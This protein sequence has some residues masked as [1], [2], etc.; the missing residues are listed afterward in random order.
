MPK[1]QAKALWGLVLA[2]GDG[3]RLQS[4]T[5]AVS[6]H[7]IPKQYCRLLNRRSLIE[8]TL[9]RVNQLIEPACTMVIVNRDHLPLARPQMPSVPLANVV[10]QPCNRDTG[11]GVL[12][13]LLALERRVGDTPVAVFPSDHF[14]DD[15]RRFNTHVCD[16]YRLLAR[17]PEKIVLLGLPSR[18]PQAGFGYIE[19]GAPLVGF[20]NGYRVAGFFE[21]P[22]P[23][24]VQRLHATGCLWNSFVMVFNVRRMLDLIRVA[25]PDAYASMAGIGR[26][27]SAEALYRQM[28]GW[29]FSQAVLADI[30]SE[31]LV[32]R[33]D[34]VYWNDWGTPQAI[35]DT[36][37]SLR[38]PA[39]TLGLHPAVTREPA[40]SAGAA[41][42]ALSAA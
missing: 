2:G 8:T 31:L 38:M 17:F 13:A 11:P 33:V 42:P 19:Q 35:Q 4:L 15:D 14:I 25:M 37:R 12:Y 9:A 23:V 7:P 6:G 5:R 22:S 10:V 32:V 24:M 16:A 36:L 41:L 20:H 40:V 29:N 1:L 30:A 21:K 34:G 3:Q 39:Q 26:G 18:H 27:G 28:E